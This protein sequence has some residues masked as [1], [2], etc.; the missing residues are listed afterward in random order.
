MIDSL[1]TYYRKNIQAAETRPVPKTKKELCDL[2]LA[3]IDFTMQD[4]TIRTVRRLL[5]EEQYRDER[6]AALATKHFDTDMC[7]RYTAIFAEMMAAGTIR[8]DDPALLAFAYTAPVS[9]M[10]LRADREP[11]FAVA[12]REQIQTFVDRFVDGL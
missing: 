1:E 9:H 4:P 2:S 11:T 8:K 5:I 7:D 6:M 3:Q 10:I 12:A